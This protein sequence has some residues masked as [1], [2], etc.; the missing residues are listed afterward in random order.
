MMTSST[1]QHPAASVTV[2]LAPR[3]GELLVS[4]DPELID[5]LHD[6][7]TLRASGAA[8]WAGTYVGKP[9]VLTYAA[10]IGSA[11]PDATTEVVDTLVS[12]TRIGVLVHLTVRRDGVA[13]SDRGLWTF[14]FDADGRITDWDT[15]PASRP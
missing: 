6:D 8:E 14:T 4:L 9:A 7:V 3:F 12:A 5:L 1:D 2:A 11:F 13:V 10:E 15:H